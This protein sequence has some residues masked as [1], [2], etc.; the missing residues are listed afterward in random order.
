MCQLDA[1]A[2]AAAARVD[3]CLDHANVGFQTLCGLQCFLLAKRDFAA[4]SS[5]AI[6]REYCFG[7]VLMDFHQG[8]CVSVQA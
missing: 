8:F 6:T 4:G 3:L 7:L 5:H 2:F 1:A